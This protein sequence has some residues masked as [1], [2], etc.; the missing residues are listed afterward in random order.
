MLPDPTLPTPEDDIARILKNFEKRISHLES[1]EGGGALTLIE[2]ILLA[3]PAATIDFQNIPTTY[4]S[5]LLLAKLRSD[6]GG[7]P[8]DGIRLRVNNDA[9]ANYDSLVFNIR[10]LATL[11]TLETLA[12]TRGS[13]GEATAGTSPAGHFAPSPGD[14]KYCRQSNMNPTS[15][16][17]LGNTATVPRSARLPATPH[18]VIVKVTMSSASLFFTK[19]P[20]TSFLRLSVS[21]TSA[22]AFISQQQPLNPRSSSS[23]PFGKVTT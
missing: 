2:D 12:A 6:R 18:L 10:E 19:E 4:L 11:N 14:A 3:A 8:V 15:N 22:S 16:G 7:A 17:S 1:L 21:A 13:I 23:L 9:G 5:L 20:H